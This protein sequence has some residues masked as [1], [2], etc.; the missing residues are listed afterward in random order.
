[1]RASCFP[2]A[3]AVGMLSVTT[4]ATAAPQAQ[5]MRDQDAAEAAAEA[6]TE[7]D[8]EDIVV[9]ATRSGKRVGDEPI[10]VEVIDAEELAEKVRMVPG[11]IAMVVAETGGLQVQVTSPGL[12]SANIRVRGLDGRY[13]QLLAD[14]L[15]LYGGQTPSLG[16]LQIPPTDLGR[17]EVIKGAASA[18]YGASALGGV[19]N[20]VSRRPRWMPEAEFVANATSRDGQDLTGYAAL[21]IGSAW[22]ASLTGGVHRQSVKDLDADG[23]ADIP[24][25]RRATLRPRLFWDGDGGAK[26]L[27]TAGYLTEDRTGGTLPGAVVPDGSPFAETQKTE[28]LDAGFTGEWPIAG[29]G[30][31]FVRASAMTQKTDRRYGTTRQNDRQSTLFGEVSMAGDAGRTSWV[32]GAALQSDRFRSAD[33]PAFNYRYTVPGVFAQLEQTLGKTVTIAGSAR[34][35]AHSRYGTYLSP[36]LSLLYK[37]AGWTVRGSLGRGFFAPTPFVEEIESAGL[38]RLAPLGD[39]KAEIADTASIDVGRTFGRTELNASVFASRVTNA[40]TL[41]PANGGGGVRIING[42]GETRTRGVELQVRHRWRQLYLSA[43]YVY[44]DAT[45]PDPLGGGRQQVARTPRHTFGA[46]AL[47]E[48]EGKGRIG[49]EAFYTGKQRLEDDPFR[50]VSRPFWQLGVSGEIRLGPAILFANFENI[51]DA[52]QSRFTRLVRPARAIDGRWTV[53]AWAPLEGFVANTGVRLR[54]GEESR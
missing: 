44:V 29:L 37:P 35:D 2:V 54:F 4:H 11:N 25:Y 36:R 42:P 51:L 5:D 40:A 9:Q 49:V 43:S 26:A 1:M 22:G 13:T 53:D 21:P 34:L 48:V 6:A 18:L 47:W 39:L 7:A 50:S 46:V 28:R 24:G 10:R 19:I 17:V 3:I 45:E 23:W 41:V 31:L 32:V 12:G 8:P 14:G 30:K 16:I 27:L 15:P 33:F 20:L 38:S 52:R